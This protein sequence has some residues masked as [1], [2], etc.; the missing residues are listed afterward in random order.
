MDATTEDEVAR[1]HS[2][3]ARV[4]RR[5]P[6]VRRSVVFMALHNV[7][8]KKLQKNSCIPVN[9]QGWLKIN[10]SN[11]MARILLEKDTRRSL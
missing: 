9:F 10:G 1:R 2:A 3:W 11:Q 8:S 4:V 7:H 5:R 6:V